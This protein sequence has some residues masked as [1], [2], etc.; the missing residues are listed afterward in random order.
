MNVAETIL[1]KIW[2]SEGYINWSDDR[3]PR[4]VCIDT[5]VELTAEETNYLLELDS[6]KEVS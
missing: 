6:I 1:K 2:E 3:D 5:H 4:I